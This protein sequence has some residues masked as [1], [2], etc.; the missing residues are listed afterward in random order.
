MNPALATNQNYLDK[1][2][3]LVA[4]FPDQQDEWASIQTATEDAR[5]LNVRSRF[6]PNLPR[7]L[8]RV[9]SA[10]ERRAAIR[11]HGL[12]REQSFVVVS[13]LVGIC[14]GRLFHRAPGVALFS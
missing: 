5:R 3:A 13:A 12:R 14:P 8:T 4:N 10:V 6:P 9:K 11:R 2:T 1:V 7:A